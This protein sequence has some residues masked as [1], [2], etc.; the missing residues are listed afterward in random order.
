METSLIRE[1]REPI[2]APIGVARPAELPQR[3]RDRAAKQEALL[4]AASKLFARHGY[5]AATT[6]EIA[7]CAGCAEGLIHRYFNGKAG[8]LLAMIQ[9]RVSQEVVDLCDL[10]LA[11]SLEMEFLQL[12]DWEVDR[13][14][15]DRDFLKVIIPRALLD[16]AL[17]KVLARIGTSRHAEAIVKRLK[18]FKACRALPPEELEAL[19]RLIGTLGFSFGFMRPVILAQDRG[20]SQ[21]MAATIA[22]VFVRSLI[23]VG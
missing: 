3:K 2:P 8:L 20:R 23:P 6:R 15:N 22:K 12:V 13:L 7:A 16:P 4:S 10:P 21:K 17:G 11:A 18:R 19:A 9:H 14:W 5:E 1:R